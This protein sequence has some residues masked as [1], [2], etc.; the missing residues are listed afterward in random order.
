MQIPN[1]E[2]LSLISSYFNKNLVIIL[3]TIKICYWIIY[4]LFNLIFIYRFTWKYIHT[5]CTPVRISYL[6]GAVSNPDLLV[7]IPKV[8]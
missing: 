8:Q 1:L 5:H 3:S 4:I 7:L 2:E 6:Y